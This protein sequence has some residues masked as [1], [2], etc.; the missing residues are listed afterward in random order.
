[1]PVMKAIMPCLVSWLGRAPQMRKAW[2]TRRQI[3]DVEAGA[4][5]KEVGV[6]LFP[7]VHSRS[8]DLSADP[9][10]GSPLFL[11]WL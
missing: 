5:Q 11:G 6:S 9:E 3:R 8:D 4:E 2:I 10:A 7:L 1:M